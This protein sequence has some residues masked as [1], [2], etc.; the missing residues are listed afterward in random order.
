[1]S[2]DLNIANVYFVFLRSTD[3]IR[4]IEINIIYLGFYTILLL[5]YTENIDK[6]YKSS[7]KA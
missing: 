2:D 6:E 4:K 1:M 5:K 7:A 3:K